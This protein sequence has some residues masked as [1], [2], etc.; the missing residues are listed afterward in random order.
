[1]QNEKEI[2]EK[3]KNKIK[4]PIFEGFFE[5]NENFK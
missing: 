1:L 3:I 2:L 4:A 5:Y